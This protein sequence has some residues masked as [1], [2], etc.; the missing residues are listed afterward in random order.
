MKAYLM[1][2]ERDFDAEQHFPPG[3][4]ALTQDLELNTLLNAMAGG[5]SLLFEVASKALLCGMTDP[6]AI[7]YRQQVLRDCLAQPAVVREIYAIAV[8]A[9]AE[10]KRIWWGIGSRYPSAILNR[11]VNVMNLFVAALKRL[12]DLADCHAPD[13]SS[14]GFTRFF[15]MIGAELGDD[16]FALVAD[17]LKRLKFRDG[18][19]VS[20]RLG[21]GN[22][23]TGY[24]LRRPRPTRRG[25]ADLVPIGN[26]SAYTLTISDRDE[27]GA[28][29]LAELSDQGINHVANALAQSADHILSFF[30]LLRTELAFYIGALNAHERLA[31]KGE[32]TC[33]PVPLPPAE[34]AFSAAGLYDPCL[35]LTVS[36]KVTGNDISA[37]SKPLVMITGANQGGKSTFLRSVGLAQLMMQSGMYVAA[38]ALKASACQGLFT[39]YKREEDA[40]MTSGKLDEELARMSDITGHITPGSILL[41]NESF[42]S[43]NEREG[44]E[45]ARQVVRAV[46]DA[47]IR[48]FFV[49]HL[50]DLA[51][52]F[53]TEPTA[54]ALFLR[55]ERQP[56]GRRTYRLAVGEPLPTSHGEDVYQDV[57]AVLPMPHHPRRHMGAPETIPAPEADRTRVQDPGSP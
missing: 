40:T 29:A 46:L 49:T 41:C 15:A 16:Y 32:P 37:D 10:E 34:A 2:P 3:V 30:R 44:S 19:L 36:S 35:A 26:R 42:A 47:G 52:S 5:D 11:A 25:L 53:Y 51:R 33:F 27:A 9:V 13:F 55:A 20:A 28:R 8:Q 4:E 56:D 7:T 18:V 21:E 54:A 48:V 23:G 45:I 6:A 14:D 43:T 17:H 22:T 31:A 39:H 24:V 38:T 50:H 12:R 1:Y 57:F